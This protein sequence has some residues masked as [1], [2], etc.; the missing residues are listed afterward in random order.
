[1]C[2]YT[3][4]YRI[5]EDLG[6]G[7]FDPKYRVQR[8]HVDEDGRLAYVSR[9]PNEFHGATIHEVWEAV[10][11]MLSAFDVPVIRANLKL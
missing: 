11:H 8:V 6:A 9:S 4:E 1:M 5:V 7:E 10:Q 3:L 2:I